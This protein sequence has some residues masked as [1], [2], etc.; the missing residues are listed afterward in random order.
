MDAAG[1][2]EIVGSIR[3]DFAQKVSGDVGGEAMLVLT[4]APALS[5]RDLAKIF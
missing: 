5:G 4:L 3:I 1:L 2:P